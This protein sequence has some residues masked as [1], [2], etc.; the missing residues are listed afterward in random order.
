MVRS[1]K[2]AILNNHLAKEKKKKI[3]K[4]RRLKKLKTFAYLGSVDINELARNK[5]SMDPILKEKNQD[6]RL[7]LKVITSPNLPQ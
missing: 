7:L 1:F 2:L 6:Y 3:K 5:A 4:K